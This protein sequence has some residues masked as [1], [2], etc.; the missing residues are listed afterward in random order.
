MEEG[1]GR[2]PGVAVGQ[3]AHAGCAGDRLPAMVGAG[4][5]S[6]HGR[7]AQQRKIG[8]RHRVSCGERNRACGLQWSA[9]SAQ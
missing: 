6:H 5:E 8:E 3:C 7:A 9:G 1:M 2:G 4:G